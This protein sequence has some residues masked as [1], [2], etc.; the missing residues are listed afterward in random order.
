M[1]KVK[2]KKRILTGIRPTGKLHLGHYVGLLSQIVDFQDQYETFLLIPDLQALTDNFDNPLKV[3]NSVLEVMFD[4]LSVGIDPNKV[5]F[6]LQSQVPATAELFVYF[7]NMTS[8]EKIQ[9]NPT[10]KNELQD[11]KKI[12]KEF[13]VSTPL[14]FFVY[15]VHQAADIMTV[16]ADLVPVGE[17]QLPMI[18]LTRDIVQKFNNLYHS[19]VF[20]MPEAKVSNFPRLPGTDGNL[21]MG[22]SLGNAIYLSDDKVVLKEKVSKM[23][24]DPTRIHPTDSGRVEGNPVFVY[25]DA[26]NSNKKEIEDLKER[27]RNGK[28][29]DVE[30]KERLFEALDDFLTPIREKRHYYEQRKSEVLDLLMGG[31]KRV[32][33]ISNKIVEGAKIAME[34]KY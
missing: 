31:T 8:V 18:E 7:L 15:P 1:S 27:Y 10:V 2:N 11:K 13:K 21:K 34:L 5:T 30:V 33:K 24:T 29:G 17:D 23:Y 6:Y 4:C 12:S 9:H 28:V 16:N 14:G 19:S 25:H 26:F 20:N 32:Q 3:R 22:K